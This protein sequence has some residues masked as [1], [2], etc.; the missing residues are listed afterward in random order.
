MS[1][2]RVIVR[3]FHFNRTNWKGVALCFIGAVIFW[4]FNSLNKNYSTNIRFPISF[5]FDQQK[6]S[7]AKAL[8]EVVIMNV[9]GT[10]WDLMRK[11][12]GLKLP[13]LIVP[14]E[15]PIE[16][17]KL[18]GSTLQGILAG[19]MGPLQI[20][21]IVTDTLYLQLESKKSKKFGLK[22]NT[23]EIL[24]KD[25][26]GLVSPAVVLPDSVLIEGPESIIQS[27]PD[28]IDIKVIGKRIDSDQIEEVEVALANVELI[29]RDPP[30]VEVR[31]EVGKIES[32]GRR[33]KLISEISDRL[34]IADSVNCV[35][36]IPS[37]Y[38]SNPEFLFENVKARVHVQDN[39]KKVKPLIEGLPSFVKL[40]QIDSVSLN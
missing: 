8:P 37:K 11:N 19:Q 5:D 21:L 28:V 20:N 23:D 35:F 29:K 22:V 13:Q 27:L 17:K 15:R 9:S 1:F 16:T 6:F 18:I 25:D 36:L 14:I 31:Y 30:V 7:P 34:D 10:G 12:F 4:L 33:I 38:S 2:F 26:F 39:F 32:I 3:L 40:I 24:F